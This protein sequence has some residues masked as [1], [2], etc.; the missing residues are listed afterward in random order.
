MKRMLTEEDRKRGGHAVQEVL[1]SR[2]EHPLRSHNFWRNATKEQR[3]Q[4]KAA[5]SARA[6]A[7]RAV[8]AVRAH[9]GFAPS[10]IPGE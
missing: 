3:R 8:V 7:E 10:D 4:H 1:L 2:G 9:Q 6:R 5:R